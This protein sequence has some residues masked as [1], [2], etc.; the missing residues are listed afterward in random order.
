MN[1]TTTTFYKLDAP[2]PVSPKCPPEMTKI[3]IDARHNKPSSFHHLH[4]NTASRANPTTQILQEA[5]LH[6]HPPTPSFL[7]HR[8][9]DYHPFASFCGSEFASPGPELRSFSTRSKLMR[10]SARRCIVRPTD[11]QPSI[12]LQTRVLAETYMTTTVTGDNCSRE[13]QQLRSPPQQQ[14][15]LRN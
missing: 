4:S 5:T 15:Q 8:S 1:P 13:E 9:Q 6:P 10:P 12:V 11:P 14:T 7:H 2:P 3:K